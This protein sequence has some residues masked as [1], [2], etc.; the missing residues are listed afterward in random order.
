MPHESYIEQTIER[1]APSP[2]SPQL[3]AK[4]DAKIIAQRRVLKVNPLT[5]TEQLLSPLGILI[6]LTSLGPE[7]VQCTAVMMIFM[8]GVRLTESSLY[9]SG[10]L[11]TEALQYSIV[12]C[13]LVGRFGKG[14][15]H[16]RS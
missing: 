15:V 4:L 9:I 2:L 6:I 8:A 5:G 12:S 16:H 1:D 10:V 11:Y 14:N 13:V 3:N 7:G